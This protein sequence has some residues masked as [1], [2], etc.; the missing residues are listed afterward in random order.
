M[1]DSK[2]LRFSK[3]PILKFVLQIFQGLVL[4]L[5]GLIG[6]KSIDVTQPI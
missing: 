4:G 3:P 1:A 2:E 6:A 5:I